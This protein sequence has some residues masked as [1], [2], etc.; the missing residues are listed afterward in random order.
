MEDLS[1]QTPSIG[2]I[3]R[4]ISATEDVGL[5]E[6]CGRIMPHFKGIFL[7]IVGKEENGKQPFQKSQLYT[8]SLRTGYD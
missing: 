4:E 7:T 3:F 2:W 8:K 5:D 6:R 1:S